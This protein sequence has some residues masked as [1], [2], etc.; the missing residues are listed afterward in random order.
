[1]EYSKPREETKIDIYN[2]VGEAFCVEAD[3]GEKVYKRIKTAFEINRKVLLSFLN[4]KMLTT[5][6]LN[7]AVGRLYKDYD[8]QFIKE[9]LRV[10][11]MT[12]SGLVSLKRVVDTAKLYYKDPQAMEES[13][14]EIL[15]E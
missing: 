15:G 6:F 2:I 3:D 11:N 1:M 5:A 14:K 8:E 7:T 9:N 13:I 12:E 10:E 4:V